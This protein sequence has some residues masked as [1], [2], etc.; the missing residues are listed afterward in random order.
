MTTEMLCFSDLLTVTPHQRT[1]TP[2]QYNKKASD[3]YYHKGVNVKETM[4]RKGKANT[5]A[6]PPKRAEY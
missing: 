4:Q 1:S 5:N 6:D 2:K 3:W